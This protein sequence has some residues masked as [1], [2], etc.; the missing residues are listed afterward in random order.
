MY[1]LIEEAADATYLVQEA[2]D[3]DRPVAREDITL[4]DAARAWRLARKAAE[5]ILNA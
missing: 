1:A 5:E 3:A 4:E 2:L